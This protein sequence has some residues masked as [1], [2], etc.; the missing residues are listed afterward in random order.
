MF[1]GTR[2]RDKR[3]WVVGK[4]KREDWETFVNVSGNF[5]TVPNFHLFPLFLNKKQP[6]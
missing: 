1:L 5:I 6:L 2:A 4:Q 3:K